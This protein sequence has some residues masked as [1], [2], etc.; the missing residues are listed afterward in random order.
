MPAV[1]RGGEWKPAAPAPIW[2]SG[3]PTP[4]FSWSPLGTYRRQ[5][6]RT[7][8][9]VTAVE[10]FSGTPGQSD[11]GGGCRPP[12][13]V[14]YNI[15]AVGLAPAQ[16]RRHFNP[17][18][19]WFELAPELS[20]MN[21]LPRRKIRKYSNYLNISTNETVFLSIKILILYIYE[22]YYWTYAKQYMYIV[23]CIV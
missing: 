13:A 20:L 23:Y 15:S 3:D 8:Q 21:W 14:L 9:V 18:W 16:G 2:N 22:I 17:L 10:A 1:N 6:T 12:C 5:R 4:S 11:G 19:Y 7:L